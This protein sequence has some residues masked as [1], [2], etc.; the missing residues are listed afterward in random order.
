MSASVNSQQGTLE[1]RSTPVFLFESILGGLSQSRF[2]S[3]SL[4]MLQIFMKMGVWG[5][6]RKHN[7]SPVG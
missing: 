2:H 3:S 6:W 7:H 5:F 4:E 1:A